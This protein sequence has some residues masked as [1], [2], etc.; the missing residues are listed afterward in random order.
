VSAHNP[1]L[2]NPEQFTVTRTPRPRARRWSRS[3]L[4]WLQSIRTPWGLELQLL[5]I[6]ESGLLVES[7]SKL[8]PASST[9]LRLFGPGMNVAV[10]VRVVRSEVAGV[11]GLGVRYRTAATFDHAFDLLP[12]SL[13]ARSPLGVPPPASPKALAALLAQVTNGLEGER[14]GALRRSFEREVQRLSAA[15]DVRV[16]DAPERLVEG[17]DSIYFTIPTDGGNKAIL[18]VTFEPHYEPAEEEF[19]LLKAAAMIAGAVLEYEPRR[20]ALPSN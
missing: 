10:P 8:V 13:P 17:G 20:L 14:P 5:N 9:E 4:R 3:D 12:D 1:D 15:R 16:C 18:Q 2:A 7:S 11:N 19:K 6:S